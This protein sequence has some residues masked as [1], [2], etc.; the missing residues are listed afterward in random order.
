MHFYTD[1]NWHCRRAGGLF[2]GIRMNFPTSNLDDLKNEKY[3]SVYFTI[4]FILFSLT[5]R[6]NYNVTKMT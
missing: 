3:N 5:F 1:I 4:G 6:V 2:F